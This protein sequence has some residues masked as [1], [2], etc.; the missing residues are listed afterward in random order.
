MAVSPV[1]VPTRNKPSGPLGGILKLVGTGLGAVGGAF[2]G[3]PVGGAALGGAAGGAI[4][5][6]VSKP[7]NIKQTQG[8]KVLSNAASQ[9]P[10]IDLSR[11]DEAIPEVARN[12]EI[13]GGEAEALIADLQRAREALKNRLGAR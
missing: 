5:S 1:E 2:V 7:G 4:G 3:N 13:G 8:V 10:E 12:P 9:R 6:V 11:I